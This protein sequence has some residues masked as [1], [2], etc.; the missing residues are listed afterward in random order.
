MIMISFI[1]Y[2]LS[3]AMAISNCYAYV[4]TTTP[5]SYKTLRMTV[6]DVLFDIG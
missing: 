1:P 6:I 5:K 3:G 2:S 4:A